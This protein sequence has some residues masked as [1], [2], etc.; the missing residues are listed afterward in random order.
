MTAPCPGK[1]QPSGLVTTP[2]FPPSLPAS[3]VASLFPDCGLLITLGVGGARYAGWL[4][5]SVMDIPRS[6]PHNKPRA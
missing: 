1:K 5:S 3:P 4:V 6:L 2:L